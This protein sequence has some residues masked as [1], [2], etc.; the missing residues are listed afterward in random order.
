MTNLKKIK[1]ELPLVSF[2]LLSKN[3]EKG[4]KRV[5]E[6]VAMQNYPKNR[7]DIVVNDDGSTDT[8]A[9][10]ARKFTKRV[11]VRP[12]GGLYGNWIYGMHKIKGEYFYYIEQ[13]IEL[14]GKNW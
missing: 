13:D 5:L 10:V 8:S 3:D 4:V 9:Q 1:K 12:G 6:S 2:L 14:R 7:L 11:F